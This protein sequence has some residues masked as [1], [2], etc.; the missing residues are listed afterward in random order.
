MLTPEAI[1]LVQP[2]KVTSA[3]YNFSEREENILT[4]MIEALQKHM[5][6]KHVI[7]TDLFGNPLLTIDVSTIGE[8]ARKSDYWKASKSLLTKTFSFEWYHKEFK[9]KVDT[10]GVLISTIHNYRD[11]NKIRLTLN[12]WAIPYLLYWGKG[13]GGTIFEKTIALK[14]NGEY[15]KRMYKL[16]K[17]FEDKGG[18]T[19][20]VQHFREMFKL[21]NKYKLITNLQ[22]RVLNPAR[23]RMKEGAEIYFEYNLSKIGGS[24]SYNQI[25]FHITGN[26]TNLKKSEK[27]E[28]YSIVYN[29]LCLAYPNTKSDRAMV[30]CDK[31]AERPEKLAQI[32]NRFKKIQNEFYSKEKTITEVV[33]L[34]KHIL[35]NDYEFTLNS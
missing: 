22:A 17:R 14:L 20:S 24:R 13:V 26:N 6:R 21:E 15:T 1:N 10:E 23:D 16:C 35:K 27:T 28:L 34:I 32:Y 4:L 19:M 8:N 18:F 29:V 7:D 30:I 12:T 25:T 33:P 5:S 2:N 11:S 9:C 31:L 3:R